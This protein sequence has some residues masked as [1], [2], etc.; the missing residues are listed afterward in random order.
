LEATLT[1]L[2][3]RAR[4]AHPTFSIS[5]HD[6]VAHLADCG[7]EPQ[8]AQ[9]TGTFHVE[10]LYLACACLNSDE[11]AI[12]Q[13]VAT[14]RPALTAAVK[15]IDP[16]PAFADE[17]LQR[18]WDSAL[19]GTISSS[20]RLAKYSGRGSLGAW[21]SVAVQREALMM[22]RHERAEDRAR[23]IGDDG[24]ALTSDPELAM[25]RQ[26]HREQF[27]VATRSALASLEDRERMIFRLHLVDGV[28]I[29][30]IARGYGVSHSTVSRWFA[31]ARGKVIAAVEQAIRAE[32]RLSP[33]EFESLKRVMLSDVELSLSALR[34]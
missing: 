27:Q 24:D 12:E 8:A 7:A 3:E 4:T 5:D 2:C 22:R 15:R 16:S 1:I 18:F 9:S 28:T 33:G 6:F 31:A 29:E 17:V 11:R 34:S 23:R 30:Q 25:L 13:L 19:I 26:S 14:Q 32:L 20:P 21:L 10:D